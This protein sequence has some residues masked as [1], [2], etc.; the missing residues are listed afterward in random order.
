MADRLGAVLSLTLHGSLAGLIVYG[1]WIGKYLPLGG[2][3][4]G[5]AAPGSMK[6]Q[7][8]NSV[9]GGAVP[10]PS[11]VVAPTKNR[12]MNDSPDPAIARS[13]MHPKAA[14]NSVA[15]PSYKPEDLARKQAL[16]DLR[17]LARADVTPSHDQRVPSGAGGRVSFSSTVGQQGAGGGGG[18][19]FGDANFGIKYA[20]W[21]NHLRDRLQ[22]YWNQQPRDPS[23]PTGQRVSVTL[24]V[25]QDGTINSIRYISRA[26][27][28]AVNSM[29]FQTV[30]QMAGA[31][32]FPLP[33]GYVPATLVITV[34]FELN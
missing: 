2:A 17:N 6:V 3:H 32:K 30:Q 15:L 11:P 19:S 12:L 22:F 33:P 20:D 21:V 27:S 16:A 5:S 29:A 14:R 25:H 23:T 8:V 1:G 10:I 24:T 4:P 34:A 28:V 9:P 31:E 13:I 18:M 26:A 7:L